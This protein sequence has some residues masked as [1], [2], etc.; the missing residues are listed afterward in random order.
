MVKIKTSKEIVLL[1]LILLF[2]FFLRIYG[3]GTAQLWVDEAISSIA[4]ENIVSK[5]LPIFD[6]GFL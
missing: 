2:A 3:L 5:A 4:S 6:S 1:V